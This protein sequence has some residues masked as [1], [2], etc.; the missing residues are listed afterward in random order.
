MEFA[1]II[2]KVKSLVPVPTISELFCA[3][4]SE[5]DEIKYLQKAPFEPLAK[6]NELPPLL[7]VR[8]LNEEHEVCL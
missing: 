7:Y 3:V 1:F 4:K 2:P 6:I 8:R 5:L